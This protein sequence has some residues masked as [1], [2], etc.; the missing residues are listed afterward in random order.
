MCLGS[1]ILAPVY[2]RCLKYGYTKENTEV[3]GSLPEIAENGV[4]NGFKPSA[5]K[6]K[7]KLD[8]EESLT[9]DPSEQ[10]KLTGEDMVI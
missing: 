2:F 7:E 6:R 10:E 4:S 3:I 1:F 8:K 9:S 5:V